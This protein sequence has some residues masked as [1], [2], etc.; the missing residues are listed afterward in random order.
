[1]SGRFCE[2]CGEGDLRPDPGGAG[3]EPVACDLCGWTGDASRLPFRCLLREEPWTKR[4]RKAAGR[5]FFLW[6]DLDA[7]RPGLP[8][9]VS[10][11]LGLPR[12]SFASRTLLELETKPG[13]EQLAR[14]RALQGVARAWL[15]P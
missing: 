3:R 4:A 2:G 13:P 6:I 1:M 14:V 11:A 7:E 12:L 8:A 9:A 15:A 10:A 5:L